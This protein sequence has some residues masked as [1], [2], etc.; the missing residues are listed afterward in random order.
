MVSLFTTRRKEGDPVHQVR[1]G[2]RG[3]GE[4]RGPGRDV[5]DGVAITD[6][7]VRQSPSSGVGLFS[8]PSTPRADQLVAHAHG[9]QT[10]LAQN[11]FLSSL[12]C[13]P[14][15]SACPDQQFSATKY[16]VHSSATFLSGHPSSH[17]VPVWS[18]AVL[19]FQFF[20]FPPPVPM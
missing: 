9:L 3:E 12:L 5:G 11:I 2:G 20:F 4:G 15:S 1:R 17:H 14:V 19:F 18:A 6:E 16:F 8:A 10:R 13:S 7:S